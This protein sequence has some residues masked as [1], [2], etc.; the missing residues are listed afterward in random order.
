M[1]LNS[2]LITGAQSLFGF[3]T[4][5]QF[6]RTTVTAVMSK[7]RSETKSITAQG[8]GKLE[9]FERYAIDYDSDRNFFLAHYFRENYDK[10][11]AEYPFIRSK[12][13]I[14][15]IEVWK[16]NRT[17][18][19]ENIRNIVALQDIGESTPANIGLD[20]PPPGFIL[21]PNTYPD[22][23]VNGFN[24]EAIGAGS[25]LTTAIRDIATVST[26]FPG[27]TANQGLD[28]VMLENA[29]KLN[30]SEYTINAELGYITLNSKLNNP[31][32]R[33]TL[34]KLATVK[35]AAIIGNMDPIDLLNRLRVAVGQTEIF[36]G[37]K[38]EDIEQEELP[39]WASDS[40]TITINANEILDTNENP[41]AV[42]NK[43]IKSLKSGEILEIIADFKPEPLL[44]EFKKQ[45]YKV[46]SYQESEDKFI[47]K[48]VK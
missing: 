48:I 43:S 10:A 33:R 40:A 46:A 14:T 26:A 8:D 20:T 45:G 29:K 12:I 24:P 25:I 3:K 28:Y 23:S 41:L 27:T 34:A 1:P 31:I 5:L 11:L 18:Q 16:T 47:S 38:K 15:K 44:E 4:Q 6:G 42:A 9:D 32:L 22:N 36:N 7:Q 39:N 35:Q 17:T 21:A 30:P 2:S 37:D 19:T 13:K